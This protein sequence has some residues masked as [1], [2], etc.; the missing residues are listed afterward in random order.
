MN[1]CDEND[2][3][4]LDE[5][6]L[7]GCKCESCGKDN[8]F[9]DDIGHFHGNAKVWTGIAHPMDGKPMCRECWIESGSRTGER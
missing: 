4:G 3:D 7:C 2:I 6:T 1:Y 8:T 5:G 9:R